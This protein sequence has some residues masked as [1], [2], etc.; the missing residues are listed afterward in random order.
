MIPTFQTSIGFVNLRAVAPLVVKM[1]VPL[2][3][4]LE[5]IILIINSNQIYDSATPDVFITNCHSAAYDSHIKLLKFSTKL[6]LVLY[7]M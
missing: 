3:Y 2:L 6:A 1:A 5:L 4:G 7:S